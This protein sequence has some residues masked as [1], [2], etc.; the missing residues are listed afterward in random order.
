MTRE[1]KKSLQLHIYSMRPKDIKQ[2]LSMTIACLLFS[3]SSLLYAEKV[4]VWLNPAVVGPSQPVTLTI[5]VES[6]NDGKP[7]LSVLEKDF[8]ILHRSNSSSISMSNGGTGGTKI[9][10]DWDVVLRKMTFPAFR[11]KCEV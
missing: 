10:R 9:R 6:S 2:Y 8:Q 3:L 1:H 4:S 5:S 7:D 11:P